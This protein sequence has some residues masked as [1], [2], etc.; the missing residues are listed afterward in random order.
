MLLQQLSV[1]LENKPGRLLEVTSVLSRANIDI[2]AVSVSDTKDFGILRLIVSDATKAYQAL[3]EANCLV[4]ISEVICVAISDEPGSLMKVIE[5]LSDGCINVEY[6]YAFLTNSKQ[7]AY[8]VLQVTDRPRATVLLE[9]AGVNL[10]SE[11]E[12]ARL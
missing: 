5:L 2:R 4:S 11:E 10:V 1:F 3:Q 8:V 7:F 12:I 9:S 6:V